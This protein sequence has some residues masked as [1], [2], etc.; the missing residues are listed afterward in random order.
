MLKILAALCLLSAML[1]AVQGTNVTSE[2]SVSSNSSFKHSGK[3]ARP[4]QR[5][6]AHRKRPLILSKT[7][8]SALLEAA[9]LDLQ[10]SDLVHWDAAKFAVYLRNINEDDARELIQD[11]IAS[12]RLGARLDIAGTPLALAGS[13]WATRSII[14]QSAYNSKNSV[15]AGLLSELSSRDFVRTLNF[16]ASLPSEPK[17]RFVKQYIYE[18]ALQS[19]FRQNPQLAWETYLTKC[20]KPFG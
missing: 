3:D 8:Q 11:I 12:G 14:S 7:S 6:I 13:T 17:N 15:L 16:M 9:G 19:G 20:S 2:Q 4:T 1:L 5:S 18:A 10:P